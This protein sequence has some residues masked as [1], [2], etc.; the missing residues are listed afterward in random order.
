MILPCV[1]LR[2]LLFWTARV[3]S[4]TFVTGGLSEWGGGASKV[5]SRA[6]GMGD[7]GV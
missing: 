1:A 4:L 7:L 3:E 5:S 2:D 6:P